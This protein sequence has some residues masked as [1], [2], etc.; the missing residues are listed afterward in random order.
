LFV[1]V[2]DDAVDSST[3]VR[4]SNNLTSPE[5]ESVPSVSQDVEVQGEDEDNIETD[6]DNTSV[7]EVRGIS[8][9]DPSVR[10]SEILS[11]GGLGKVPILNTSFTLLVQLLLPTISQLRYLQYQVSGP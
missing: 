9:K 3:T 1:A 11:I 8:K 10:R 5:E 2:Q 7:K 6:G 4:N